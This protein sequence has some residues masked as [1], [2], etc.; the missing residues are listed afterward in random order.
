[1]PN[2]SIKNEKLY[3]DL[4]KKGDSKE[5]AA[6]ISNAVAG[7]G[8]S[9]V[10]RKGGKSQSYDEWTV[11]QLRKKAKELGMTGYSSLTKDKLISKLRNH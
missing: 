5:K 7:Q 8:E 10:G 4:R 1:M 2:S 9:K 3:Q 11:P 6:R